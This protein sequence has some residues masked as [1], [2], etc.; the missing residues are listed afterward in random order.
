MR[1]RGTMLAAGLLIAA[2]GCQLPQRF[3]GKAGVHIGSTR[4]GLALLPADFYALH[5][6]LEKLFDGPVLFDPGLTVEGIAQHLRAGRIQFAILHPAEYCGMKDASSLEPIAAAQFE[7]GATTQKGL[8]VTKNDSS[9]KNVTECKGKRFAFGPAKDML[10]D[11]AARTALIQ[12]AVGE[13]DI[14]RELIPPFT[15]TGRIHLGSGLDVAKAVAFDATIPAGVVDE[16]TFNGLPATGGSFLTSPSRDMFRVLGVTP[17]VP[18]QI[19]LAGPKTDPVMVE[20][21]K[22]YLIGRVKSEEQVKSQLKVAGFGDVDVDAFLVARK[23]VT[24]L[25]K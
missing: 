11:Y 8:I 4:I 12:Q 25:G 2:T 7:G 6:Q 15:L 14:V 21:M 23:M 18:G 24:E 1:R 20:K 9:I 19:V 5:P 3:S 17:P 16:A 10:Y 13:G 22:Q